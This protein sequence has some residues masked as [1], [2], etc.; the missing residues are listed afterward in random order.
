M[1]G[2]DELPVG[3]KS[4]A[5]GIWIAAALGAGAMWATLRA[6]AWLRSPF[7]RPLP[8]PPPPPRRR[9]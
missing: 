7:V 3:W 9:P 2:D 8:D 4:V 5:V 6:A 1:S